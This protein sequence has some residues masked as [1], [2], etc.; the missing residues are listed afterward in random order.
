MK[1]N[2][3]TVTFALASV[4]TLKA[5]PITLTRAAQLAGPFMVADTEPALVK[6]ASRS[7]TQ[8]KRL[9][10]SVLQTSPYYVFSRGAGC[11]FVIVSGDDCLP[12]IIGYTENGDYDEALLPPAL[13]G[14]L[15]NIGNAVEAAQA[16]GQNVSRKSS[17]RANAPTAA[18]TSAKT[19]ISPLCTTHWHQSWPY[20]NRCPYITGTTNRAATGCVATAATQVAFY[21]RKDLPATLPA[22]TPTYSYGDAPVTESLPAGTPMK[23]DLMLDSYGSEPSEYED[24]VADFMFAMGAAT[25]LTYGSST[26]GQISDVVNTYNKY[27]NLSSTCIY[28]S[29]VS[30][31]TTWENMIYGDLAEGC[32]LIYTG[33]VESSGGHAVLIDGY[34]ASSNLFHFNFGWGGQ[35]DGYFTVDDETGMNGFIYWQGMTYQVRPLQPNLS[36]AISLPEGF[37]YNHANTVRLTLTNNGTLDYSGLYLFASTSNSTPTA[38]SGAKASNTATLL[39]NDGTSVSIDLSLKP[40]Q[41]GTWY[42]TLTDK[43]L[44]V[45][46]QTTT[47]PDTASYSLDVNRLSVLGSSDTEQH[48]GH[49]YQVVYGSRAT[50]VAHVTNTSDIAYDDNPYVELYASDDDGATFTLVGTRICTSADV[51]V[52]SEGEFSY[53]FTPSSSSCPVEVGK[54]YYARLRQPLSKRSDAN[55]RF[56]SADSIVRF[57]LATPDE[58]LT[59][60]LD[61][62]TLTFAGTWDAYQFSTL[63]ARSAN[64]GALSY[65]L[66]AVTSVADV[67]SV[68]GKPNAIFYAAA[69][70]SATGV[71]VVRGDVADTLSLTFGA[72]FIPPRP[73]TARAASFSLAGTTPTAWNLVTVPFVLDLPDGIV[74][75]EIDAH[76]AAGINNKTTTLRTLT[77]GRTYLLMPA[78]DRTLTLHATQTSVAAAP[79]VNADT[80]VIG[81]YTAA[82][83]PAGAFRLETGDTQYF[84]PQ[85][86]DFSVTAFSGWFSA[87][88]VTNQFGASSNRSI[89]PGYLALAQDIQAA[90]DIY[91]SCAGIATEQARA[92]LA[93]SLAA[94]Q[95]VFAL[96]TLSS[97]RLAY[98]Y[99]D[100]LL[101]L[102]QRVAATYQNHLDVA[103]DL[104][105]YIVNPSFEKSASTTATAGSLMGWTADG[106]GVSVRS[107]TANAYRGVGADG[108]YLLYSRQSDTDEGSSVRQTV[109][110][111]PSG[112]YSLTARVGTS[113]GDSVTLFAND[114]TATVSAHSFGQYY[115]TTA[116]IDSIVITDADSLTLGIRAGHW[117]KADD[118]RLVRL[119]SLT[120]EEDP[121]AIVAVSS[122]ARPQLSVQ[123]GPGCIILS[124]AVPQRVSIHTPSGALVRQLPSLSG[125]VRIPLPAG[126]YVVGGVKVYV[127]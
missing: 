96:R 100:S 22:A 11:G 75:K 113:E 84:V 109:H 118:F 122:D 68:E 77:A 89:D 5:D 90:W 15:E 51:P 60:T 81:T 20:N 115:L 120:A 80:A 93:D 87:S 76:S 114:E 99:G 121:V 33:Y 37:H 29:S 73:F 7:A 94:A 124:A 82:T 83:A 95:H 27:F 78:S 2:F 38:L 112:L 31:Q 52:G 59:A 17:S 69:G 12:D 126:L 24:A 62:T 35:G 44:H 43:N 98:A 106:T 70:S 64:S 57:I 103:V 105:G 3:L 71:N 55:L 86:A 101:A 32:P 48:Q 10:A 14:W 47:T 41:K 102:A 8:S 108:N 74:G 67:P 116:S 85:D 49:T 61:S 26:S 45:L 16:A 9:P 1:K 125:T 63:A 21:F 123:A 4:L 53:L 119:R 65:D 18:A 92:T 23:Y 79:V 91:D 88:N 117:Y 6:R 56:L 42:L 127:H 111:L 50:V 107:A 110:G 19:D 28:K 39:P 46:A 58:E 25:Y 34:Q 54:P 13:L 97:M 30:S 66:T 40:A 36:A 104:T 72:D